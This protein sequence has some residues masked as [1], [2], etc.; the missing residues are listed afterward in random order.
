MVE[1]TKIIEELEK[2]VEMYVK[3]K[4][5][6]MRR[7]TEKWRKIISLLK[8][9]KLSKEDV[10]EALGMLC[11]RSLAYCCGLE[12]KC[13]YRDTV[14]AIL[15]ISEEEYKEVKKKADEMFRS[16]VKWGEE[17]ENR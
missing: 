9:E 17:S 15:G 16:R 4:E 7:T 14:L 1:K 11:F 12:K 3:T 6:E 8:K 13:P 2:Q 10:E 5:E